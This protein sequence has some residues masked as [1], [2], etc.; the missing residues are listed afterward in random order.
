VQTFN[1]LFKQRTWCK[2]WT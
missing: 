1:I 2:R